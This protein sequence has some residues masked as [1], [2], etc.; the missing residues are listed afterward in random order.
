MARGLSL[1][2]H[3]AEH[4]PDSLEALTRLTGWPKSSV[5]RLLETLEQAAMIRRDPVS[6]LYTTRVALVSVNPT[7]SPTL[8]ERMQPL[9]PSL[10]AETNC[11]VELYALRNAGLTMI[12]RWEPPAAEVTVR[13]RVGFVRCLTELDALSQVMHAFG[14]TSL[15]PPGRR[16]AWVNGVATTLSSAQRQHR[17]EQAQATVLGTDPQPNEFGVRRCAVPLF[18]SEQQLEGVLAL[19]FVAGLPQTPV[20]PQ[21]VAALG[22][23]A[24]TATST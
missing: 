4:G 22:Q 21:W 9:G 24:H 12:D 23:A 19:A 18:D 7:S 16:W 1:L 5:A 15:L 3:L 13:A 11:T 14:Q 8:R 6:R 2:R 10:A 17:I 20:N